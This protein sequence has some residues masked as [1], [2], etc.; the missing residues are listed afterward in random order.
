MEDKLLYRINISGWVQGVG[1]RWRTALEAK[2]L[3]I[4]GYVRNLRDGRVYIEAEG[5]LDQLDQFVEW[6]KNGPGV[7]KDVNVE[8]FPPAG[9]KEFRIE[10]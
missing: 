6:C 9:Y 8:T 5:S 7:V 3:G 4:K 1:F 2:R 10:H